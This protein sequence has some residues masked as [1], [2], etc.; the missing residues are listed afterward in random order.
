MK[1]SL[2]IVFAGTPDFGIPCLE[3]LLKSDHELVAVYTQPDRPSGRGR[4]LQSPAVKIWAEENSIPV[5]QPLNFKN[6]I[7]VDELAALTPDVIVVI[8]YGLILPTKVLNIPMYGCINVHASI[9]PKWRGASPI[10]HAILN[11]DLETG[12]TIM[13]MD[14]GMDTGD[15]YTIETCPIHTDDTTSILHDRLAKIATDPLLKT[16]EKIANHQAVATQQDGSQAT[17]SP[18]ITKEDA[19][20]NWQQSAKEINQRI[21]AFSPW[22]LA[23]TATP[24]QAFQVLKAE[25][26]NEKNSSLPGTIVSISKKGMLINT[27]L[28]SLLITELRFPGKKTISISDYLNSSRTQL[29]V[30]MILK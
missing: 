26:I 5:Y 12:V 20:I 19:K 16:L 27:N 2:R 1:K 11:G 13:Q 18:K 29:Q 8:A 6:Q 21:R 15:F 30:G 22:P 28:G 10:Q 4:K 23:F 3:G 25:V 24:E 9:L 14:K 7:D 17:Y